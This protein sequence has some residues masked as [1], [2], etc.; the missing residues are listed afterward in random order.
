[1]WRLCKLGYQHEPAMLLA[2]F[3]IAAGCSPG[4]LLALWFK[5]LARPLMETSVVRFAASHLPFHP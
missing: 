5:W 2:S 3:F 1:M 4:A